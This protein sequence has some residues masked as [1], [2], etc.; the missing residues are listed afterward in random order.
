LLIF[1]SLSNQTA[2]LFQADDL[3]A[4]IQTS[5]NETIKL[6]NQDSSYQKII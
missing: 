4:A 6:E 5:F 2:M 3:K 1:V